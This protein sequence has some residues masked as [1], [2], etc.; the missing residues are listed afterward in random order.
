MQSLIEIRDSLVIG[1]AILLIFI[2]F[3]EKRNNK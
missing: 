1:I 3:S 2:F